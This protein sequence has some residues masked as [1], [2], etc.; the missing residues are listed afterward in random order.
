MGNEVVGDD[1]EHRVK[2]GLLLAGHASRGF[3]AR[4]PVPQSIDGAL[5]TDP[6]RS[7]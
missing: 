1:F 7:T 2:Q 3:E 5:E 4:T 6:V